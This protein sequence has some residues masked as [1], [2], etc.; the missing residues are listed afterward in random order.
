MEFAREGG[1]TA[2]AR[3]AARRSRRHSGE[4]VIAMRHVRFRAFLTLDAAGGSEPY[5]EYPS[6]SHDLMIHCGRLDKPA[7][8][9]LFPAAIYSDD[10]EPLHSGDTD[11]LATVELSDE[12]A[13]EFLGPGQHIMLWNGHDC[14]HG[15]ISRQDVVLRPF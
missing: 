2:R 4:K 7:V 6:G 5:R 13:C 1:G 11:V 3:S 14:G 10:D 8:R 12:H 15:V 9:Q